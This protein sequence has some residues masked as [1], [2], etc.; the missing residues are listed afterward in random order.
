MATDLKIELDYD[1]PEPSRLEEVDLIRADVSPSGSE[2]NANGKRTVPLS[3][4]FVS[5]EAE[6]LQLSQWLATAEYEVGQKRAMLQWIMSSRS[7][8]MTSW[9]RAI[10][11][12]VQRVRASTLKDDAEFLGDL[13]T[14]V[15]GS[16]ISSFV[17]VSGWA[18]S[19]HDRIET[20]EVFLE[21]LPIGTLQYIHSRPDIS[22]YPSQAPINCGYEGKVLVDDSFA[23]WRDLTV[24]VTDRRGKI[25][26]FHRRLFVDAPFR[27]ASSRALP[28]ESE[29]SATGAV[30]RDDLSVAKRLQTS[31]ARISLQ[32]F[33][34]SGAT[35]EFP[36]TTDPAV[37]I[38]VVLYNR[39][40]LTLQC[41]Y[42][43][44]K[45]Q[46][47]SYE[48]VIVDNASTD[49]TGALLNRIKGAHIIRN[50]QNLHYLHACKQASQRASGR[51]LLF[52]NN[53]AQ[54]EPQ[55]ISAAMRTLMSSDDIGAVGGKIILPD[56]TLQ[57]AG[58]IVWQ[59]GSCRGYGRGSSSLDPSFMF[60][61]DVDYCSAAFLMTHRDLFLACEGFD[62]A[63]LPAY[64][65]DTDY[66]V[67]LWQRGKRVVYD[68]DVVVI[69]HESASSGSLEA[70]LNLQASHQGVFAARHRDWLQQQPKPMNTL[71]ARSHLR[72][73]ALRILLL[74]DRVPHV[75]LG[76]GFPRSNRILHHLVAMGHQVT[77]YPLTITQENWQSIYEDIPREVE[78][79]IDH[80]MPLLAKFLTDRL[81]YYDVLFIS[82][83]HNLANLRELMRQ[84]P[85]LFQGIRK[86]YD[87]EALF[88][89]RD[90]EQKQ[91]KG[92][93]ICSTERN[94]L[95]AK[96][97]ELAECCDS[98][99]SVSDLES[100]E[101]AGYGLGVSVLGH[102]LKVAPSPN[103]FADRKDFLFVGAIHQANSPNADSVLWFSRKILPRL[104]KMLGQQVKLKIVGVMSASI[105][106]ELD[107]ESIEL[108]GVVQ[109][110]GELYNQCR[111]FVAPTR[112][113]SGLPHKVHE[114]AAHGVPIVATSSAGRQLGWTNG[115]EL[116]L[117]DDEKAFAEACAR[118]YLDGELWNRLRENA[119]DRVTRECSPE[120]FTEKLK[121]IL[122]P[123]EQ[124]KSYAVAA[125]RSGTS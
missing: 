76:S 48:V 30:L 122:V 15:A 41:L 111:I 56:G 65:E 88:S 52:V 61:R 116:L 78:V 84:Q 36:Q 26:D 4:R 107:E 66:C 98:V 5:Y 103:S 50:S 92:K 22:E 79:M 70:V 85:H 7:W 6:I 108:K 54:P 86:I 51:Y 106:A 74:D 19:L 123:I 21:S 119:L 73:G 53:D 62:E 27:P 101:F 80:G 59:E 68:P 124:A 117:A 47:A 97:I 1:N 69:H 109:D 121:T 14:P 25:R 77:F 32:N 16:R 43:I 71:F 64:Y 39:A 110:L 112:F 28:P 115:E 9:L 120:A 75:T 2:G 87:A 113:S 31:L 104:Q 3:D 82:R 57:E 125:G 13:E 33:L 38:I 8:K 55:S 67:R 102:A 37:S 93:K 34:V 12:L 90:I 105:E 63:Y 11:F 72:K 83:P 99:V 44:L 96:E 46:T 114:A 24:R 29:Y 18:H 60:K 58:S 40:E 91:L 20:V 17:N 49:E 100:R 94:Q 42:S 45:S 10:K 89:L 118:L 81:G 35:L 95:V 23:G